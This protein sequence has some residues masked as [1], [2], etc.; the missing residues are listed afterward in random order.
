MAHSSPVQLS[1]Q[2]V[3]DFGLLHPAGRGSSSD[4]LTRRSDGKLRGGSAACA[5][6]GPPSLAAL[7]AAMSRSFSPPPPSAAAGGGPPKQHST[8]LVGGFSLAEPAD[9][10]AYRSHAAPADITRLWAPRPAAAP[11]P[12]VRLVPV[13]AAEA[14]PQVRSSPALHTVVAPSPLAGVVAAD[15]SLAAE[16]QALISHA[17]HASRLAPDKQVHSYSCLHLSVSTAQPVIDHS[18][19]VL[20]SPSSSPRQSIL[21]ALKL[22]GNCSDP[23]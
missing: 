23:L 10:A 14:A 5:S 17:L 2:W 15:I 4:T 22:S 12:L 21:T 6:A 18:F 8:Q 3:N 7:A 1:H 19:S 11:K 16:A 9:S 13:E 20:A